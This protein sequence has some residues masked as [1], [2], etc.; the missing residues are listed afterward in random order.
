MTAEDKLRFELGKCFNILD[1]DQLNKIT[2]SI[3]TYINENRKLATSFTEGV[4]GYLLYKNP[5]AFVQLLRALKDNY[6][7]K[8][9]ECLLMLIRDPDIIFP[10]GLLFL[11][12]ANYV[13]HKRRTDSL[14]IEA[15]NIAR[16]ADLFE[17]DYKVSWD[18]YFYDFEY[19][20]IYLLIRELFK[21]LNF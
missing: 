3:F 4:L 7:L 15:S 2:D 14:S 10:Y 6:L 18:S 13:F 21:E 19:I 1:D 5:E 20:S 11:T 17:R 8:F 12:E 9:P 16:F